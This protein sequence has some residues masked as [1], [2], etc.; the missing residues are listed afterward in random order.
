VAEL[1][2]GLLV[3]LAV[4]LVFSFFTAPAGACAVLARRRHRFALGWFVAGLVFHFIAVLVVALLPDTEQHCPR[5]KERFEVGDWRCAQCGDA[6]PTAN[7]LARMG[8]DIGRFQQQCPSCLRPY[9]LSDYRPDA[10]EILC[11]WCKAPL[12]REPAPI[13]RPA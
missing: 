1:P 11:S 13:A 9:S 2:D 10:I 6:L 7:A 3:T 8:G 5:C 12:P 4:V